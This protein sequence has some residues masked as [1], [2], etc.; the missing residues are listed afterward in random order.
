MVFCLPCWRGRG[1]GLE[2]TAVA[3]VRAA[4]AV[5]SAGVE[6]GRPSIGLLPSEIEPALDPGAG[7]VILYTVRIASL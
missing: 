2:S 1:D 5:E 3:R 7:A 4:V 6:I